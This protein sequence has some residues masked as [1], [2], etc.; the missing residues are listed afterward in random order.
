MRKVKWK[1]RLYRVRGY[2]R[3]AAAVGLTASTGS[4]ALFVQQIPNAR[5]N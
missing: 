4:D 2:V 5:A 1:H 3:L